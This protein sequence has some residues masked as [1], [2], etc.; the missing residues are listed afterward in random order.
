MPYRREM[1][2]TADHVRRIGSTVLQAVVTGSWTAAG[3]L[4]PGKR[5]VV[6]AATVAAGTAISWV[7][8]PPEDRPAP[9]TEKSG[10]P[11]PEAKHSNAAALAAT[12]LAVG[13]IVGTRVL[14]KRWRERL[15][16]AGHPHPHRALG[17]RLGLLSVAG[18]VAANVVTAYTKK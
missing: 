4:P 6:R 10:P 3:E 12:V 18:S 15:R 7:I 14:E 2:R 1:A 17:L 16:R 9:G 5:R 11:E 8:S 13:V